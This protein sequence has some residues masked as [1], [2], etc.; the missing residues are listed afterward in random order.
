MSIFF[1]DVFD[2][3]L[4]QKEVFKLTITADDTVEEITKLL[5]S[6]NAVPEMICIITPFL[7]QIIRLLET[8]ISKLVGV[9][10][11][12]YYPSQQLELIK[13]QEFFNSL[14]EIRYS[15]KQKFNL[16]KQTLSNFAHIIGATG[17]Y[18]NDE[19]ILPDQITAIYLTWLT[20]SIDNNYTDEN[21][22]IFKEDQ[23]VGLITL[24][25]KDKKGYIDLLVVEQDY[26]N[27]GLGKMLMQKALEFFKQREISD[28]KVITEAEN[29]RANVFYQKNGFL[30]N[31]TALIY[32]Y[33]T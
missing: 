1:K 9:R 22:G 4:L 16:S 12:Y 32:H 31:G 11:V 3:T 28:I 6:Q 14:F 33:Y 5:D 7:P 19:S 17:R 8:K 30:L 13:N 10:N 18:H 27:Q 15:S 20:N 29:I 24:K 23:L 26:Q 2:S 21:I 25:I